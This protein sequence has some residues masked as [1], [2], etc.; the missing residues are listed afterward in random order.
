M[1]RVDEHGRRVALDGARR[2]RI[3]LFRHGAVDYMDADGMVVPD[4]DVVDLNEKGRAQAAAMHDVFTGVTVD[5]AV[6][7]GLPR[8]RQTGELVLG[9]RNLEIGTVAEFREIQQLQ[10][11]YVGDYD[12][13][14]DVAFIH[15]QAPNEGAQFLAGE[16]YRPFFERVAGAMNSL[17]TEPDWHN[18]AIF[19]HGGTNAA[20]LGWAT[21]VGLRAFGMF[22]QATCCL[23]ILDIDVD[24]NGKALRKIVR[25]LNVTADDPAKADRHG[26][27]MESLATWIIGS[28]GGPD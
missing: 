1:A 23:N 11:E 3:Y 4:T 27:D 21:D 22:D 14:D 2:R 16:H 6:C 25:A 28:A 17:L 15:W 12:V 9:E 24:E 18:L 5:R 8:T 19:A 7:S 26:S 20:I 10:G 13:I